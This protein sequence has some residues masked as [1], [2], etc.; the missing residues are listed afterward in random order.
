MTPLRLAAITCLCM[1]S[2]LAQPARLSNISTRGPVGTDASNM[3][4]GFVI[5]GGPKTVLVRAIGPTLES[6]G[7]PGPLANPTVTIFNDQNVAVATND[8]WKAADAATFGVVGA[9][10]LP[11]S[12]KDAVIVTTLQPGSYTAQISGLGTANTGVG[13]LE[14]YD[15]SGGGQLVNIATRLPVGTG[16]NAAFAGFVVAP[17]SGTRKLLVRGIGPALGTYGLSGLLPDPKLTILDAN[18]GEVAV[19]TANGTASALTTAANQAGAFAITAA[20]TAVIITVAPGTYTAQLSGNSGTTSGIGIVEVYDVTNAS[21][22]PPAFGQ[23]PRLFFTN[24]RGGATGS[25]ASGYGTVL[26]DPN[27]NTAT[28]SVSFSN[29]SSAQSGAHLVLGAASGNGTFIYNLPRG[30]V[31]G[32]YWAITPQGQYSV[33][34]IVSAL[35]TGNISQQID[36]ASFPAGELRS[37]LISTAGST[38]FTA[39]VAPPALA[40]GALTSPTQTDTARF[41]TQATFGPTPAAIAA[42]QARGINGWIDDQFAL[43]ATSAVASLN[44]DATTYPNPRRAD[45]GYFYFTHWNWH[46]AWWKMALT[47]SDQLRQRVAFALS[48]LLVVGQ[49]STIP[50]KAKVR[51]YDLLVSGAFGNFRQLLDDISQN[52]A[53]GRWLSFESNQKANPVTGTSPDENYAREVMQLFTIGL[54]QLQPDGT[55][56]LDATGQPIPTY[57]QSMVSE[58]AKVFTGWTFATLP[59]TTSQVS[60]F[61]NVFAP[62][63]DTEVLPE[64]TAWLTPFRYYDAFHDKTAKSILSLQQVL[65]TSAQPTVIPA[66]QAG[67]QDMKAALDVLFNHPNCGPFVSRHLIKFLVTSNPSPGYVYRVAQKFA[68]DGTGTRGNLGAVVRAILTDYEAR[69][70]AVLNNIGYGKIKEPLLRFSAFFRALNARAANGRFLDSFFG[71]PRNPNPT[72]SDAPTGFLSFPLN[73]TSQMPLY[74]RSVFNFFSPTYSPP[75]PMAAAGLVAP[76]LEITDGTFGLFLPNTFVDFIYRDTATLPTPPSGPSPYIELDYSPFLPNAKNSTALVDQLNLIFCGGQMTTATRTQI[77]TALQALA[78]STSDKERVQ[79]AL[80]LTVISPA[81]ATQK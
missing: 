10:P 5:R 36:T 53:M 12:S 11:A 39:P 46:P 60:Q 74:A 2:L 34:D 1:A 25:T 69:S 32:A 61:T 40:A 49:L 64:D 19:A 47:T 42:L 81:A 48:E 80:H 52:P 3:F 14:V 65:P 79:T 70:P 57:N 75:G 59:A 77:I 16:A 54:V 72:F 45:L 20:D 28:V 9:F 41:L 18:N 7:V 31:S 67:P 62:D 66:N 15:V 51:Y 35:L 78:S 22:L 33:N 24:L 4:G 30:Q 63:P 13:L 27:T 29:L 38:S 8:D 56:M 50:V 76:E 6:F 26:F 43:P 71:D 17:G 23:S 68:D 44:Y 21:G 37:N 55:L 73:Q 58:M